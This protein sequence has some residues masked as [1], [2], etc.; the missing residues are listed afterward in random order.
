[1]SSCEYYWGEG[2]RRMLT[3]GEGKSKLII[4]GCNI[5]QLGADRGFRGGFYES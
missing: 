5:L 1:M 4:G 2:G 3:S